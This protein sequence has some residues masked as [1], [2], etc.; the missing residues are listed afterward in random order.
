MNRVVGSGARWERGCGLDGAGHIIVLRLRCVEAVVLLGESSL[1][2]LPSLPRYWS[3]LNVARWLSHGGRNCKWTRVNDGTR[4]LTRCFDPARDTR[5]RD[6]RGRDSRGC[7]TAL[8]R[9]YLILGL[10]APRFGT[11]RMFV[12][13]IGEASIT[14]Y[15]HCS[16][17]PCE[18]MLWRSTKRAKCF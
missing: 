5:G 2:S 15:E 11:G 4:D 16:N 6:T 14:W 10:F 7:T 12:R 17:V 3:I 9:L 1:P 13:A 8:Q 18:H